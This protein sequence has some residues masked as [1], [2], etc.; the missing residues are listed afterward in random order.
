MQQL[1]SLMAAMEGET[2]KVRRPRVDVL[3]RPA[4]G[5]FSLVDYDRADALLEAG[6]R[7]AREHL[8]ALGVVRQRSAIDRR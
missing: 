1:V 7:A 8:E 2:L 5:H 4:V 6:V 3:V